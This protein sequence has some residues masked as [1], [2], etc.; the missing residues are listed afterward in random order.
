MHLILPTNECKLAKRA[1]TT[2]VEEL[3][4]G[5]IEVNNDLLIGGVHRTS[6]NLGKSGICG[7]I[8]TSSLRRGR[9]G[10]ISPISSFCCGGE[11]GIDPVSSVCYGGVSSTDKGAHLLLFLFFPGLFIAAFFL[12]TKVIVMFFLV[13]SSLDCE[14]LHPSIENSFQLVPKEALNFANFLDIDRYGF[15][16]GV[17][18]LKAR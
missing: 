15:S 7:M 9:E 5:T 17:F 11:G 10:G 2:K 16:I 18:L 12:L 1:E 13:K 8:P 4:T 14:L 3:K 6:W